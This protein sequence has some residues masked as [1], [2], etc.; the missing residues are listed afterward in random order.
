MTAPR[1]GSARRPIAR[2]HRQL[3]VCVEGNTEEQYLKDWARRLRASVLITVDSIRGN[4]LTLVKHARE[5]KRAEARDA[6]R[7]RG[8]TFD[9]YW[10]VFDVD[11]H[12]HL[13]DALDMA[14]GNEISVALSNPCLELWLVI[15]FEDSR[16]H[17]DRWT[18]QR[19]SEQILRCA[20]NLDPEA[21][22][23]LH[24]THEEAI[25]RARQLARDHESAGSDP[26]SN[27]S[28]TMFEL[29]QSIKLT[30]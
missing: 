7:G 21:L 14:S 30:A 16:A 29:V 6:R 3:F 28:S 1:R 5:V 23:R 18:V 26:T 9:E 22:D 20:K 19:R 13:H 11:S 24:L 10:C 2:K 4:P 8:T 25:R 17:I 27:P 12:D 15:H